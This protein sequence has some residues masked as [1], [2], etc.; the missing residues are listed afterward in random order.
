MVDILKMETEDIIN[1]AE[2]LTNL[3]S[4]IDE[5]ST[6][7]SQLCEEIRVSSSSMYRLLRVI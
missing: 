6:P 5:L 1:L 7:V 4:K 3:S 2:S